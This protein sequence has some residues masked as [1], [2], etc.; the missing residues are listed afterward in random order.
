[1]LLRNRQLYAETNEALAEM[2]G[3]EAAE[4]EAAVARGDTVTLHCHWLS[5]IRDLQST[6]MSERAAFV[7]FAEGLKYQ[8]R[9]L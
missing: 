3:S 9:C 6:F 7:T 1:M 5:F 4:E 2:L 8:Q